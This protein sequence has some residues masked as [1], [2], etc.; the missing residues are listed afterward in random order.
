LKISVVILNWNGAEYLRK[1][2]PALIRHTQFPNVEIVIADNGSTDNSFEVLSAEFPSL[3]VIELG[4]NFGFAGGYNRALAQLDSE[5]FLLLNSDVEVTENWLAPMLDYMQKHPNVVACQPKI[6]SFYNKEYFE[7]AGASGGFIDKF[8]YPFCRGRIL[9]TTEKDTGQYDN[10]T[11]IFWATGACFLVRADA[12]WEMG[13]FD[14]DFFAHMEEIDLC[15]RLRNKGYE[16]VCI[17]QSVVYHVGGGTLNTESPYKTYLNFRNN[18]LMLYKNLPA[19]KLRKTMFVRFFLDYLASFH[20]M[21][22]GK[23]ANAFKVFKARRDYKK[24]RC[25]YLEIRKNAASSE[26]SEVYPKSIIFQYYLRGKKRYSCLNQ[27]FY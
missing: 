7:Y 10:I 5:Y 20:L 12:F 23:L 14:A 13:G 24:M 6:R 18:L 9:G 17:P 1:F 3:R 26:I 19:N 4:K 22:G 15:W 16:I 27:D 2:L 8:G 25:N 11:P 21:L